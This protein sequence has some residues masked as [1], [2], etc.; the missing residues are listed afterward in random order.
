MSSNKNRAAIY[1]KPGELSI[2]VVDLEIPEPGAGEVLVKLTHSGVC[3]SDYG[4]M[5]NGWKFLPAPTAEGQVGGHE[6]VGEVIS[7]GS[8]ADTSAIKVGQR[9]GIKW[10]AGICH[11]CPACLSNHD[12]SCPSQ[13]ISGYYTPGTF[14]QYVCSPANYVTPIPDGLDSAEAAPLLCAGVTVYSALKKANTESGGFV[15][16]LGAGGGLGHL[17]VQI[18][19]RGFKMRVIGIDHGSKKDLVMQSGAEQFIDHT[20]EKDIPGKVKEY[21]EGLGAHA[22][23]V[24]T[25]AN[26]AY[27][28]AIPLLRFAG[29]VV[30]VGIPEGELQPVASACPGPMIQHELKLVGSAVGTRLDAIKTLDLAKRG[31]IKSHHRIAKLDE[32]QSIFEEMHRGAIN[33]RVV[34]DLQA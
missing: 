20:Q 18:A 28:S 12:A 21:T 13:K 19:S 5:T 22:V 6:G 27:A 17:A 15:V 8:G 11:S 14:Q 34:L 32:L 23:V 10:L 29:T 3:H 24:L 16:V 1:D 25:A 31:V 9:V 4:I 7:L 30:A 2:K 33:G 26:G